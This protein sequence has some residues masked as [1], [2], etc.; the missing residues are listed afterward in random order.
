MPG[1]CPASLVLTI[2]IV[3][4]HLGDRPQ[5]FNPGTPTR[6]DETGPWCSARRAG[7][8]SV[9]SRSPTPRP[10]I[11]GRRAAR[12]RPRVRRGDRRHADDR[13][14]VTAIHRSCLRNGRHA[15]S[16]GSPRRAPGRDE[17]APGPGSILYLAAILMVISRGST[18]LR[19][20]EPMVVQ[21]RALQEG[22]ISAAEEPS[23]RHHPP[24]PT[25]LMPAQP[26]SRL[27]RRSPTLA[28]MLAV[29]VRRLSCSVR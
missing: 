9:A 3:P 22:L 6:P 26:S 17:P 2:M 23:A 13:R 25:V 29:A 1:S 15:R 27:S 18:H 21:V 8:R 4:D 7:R 28:A 24:A 10:G 20:A 11:V 16:A 19:R 5:A 12:A 14:R